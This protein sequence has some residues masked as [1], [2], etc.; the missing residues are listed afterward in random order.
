[1]LCNAASVDQSGL[2]SILGGFID[3]LAGPQ[4]PV[5]GQ[6]WLVARFDWEEADF[7]SQHTVTV[8]IE[9]LDD[10]EQIAR[11]DGT[12]VAERPPPGA[13]DPDMPIGWNIVIPVAV[14]FRRTG[15]HRVSL[16][17][18]AEPRWDT[19]LKVDTQLPQV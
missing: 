7:D 15:L 14:E 10:G 6:L 13:I 8:R 4:L 17:V 9:R 12:S 2:V 16:S 5:R 11:V 3:R 19:L 1:M 18:D